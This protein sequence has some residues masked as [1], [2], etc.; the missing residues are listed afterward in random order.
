MKKYLLGLL[1]VFT[2]ISSIGVWNLNAAAPRQ[3]SSGIAKTN[4]NDGGKSFRSENKKIVFQ[5]HQRNLE[6]H[7]YKHRSEFPEYKTMQEYGQGAVDF[8]SKPPAGTKFKRRSNGDR[9]FYYEKKNMFGVT[10]GK[11]FIKTF[12]R[13]NN[14]RKYW[15]RQ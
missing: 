1:V 2:C 5:W 8:F 9:L 7:F 3:N 14:G 13:P 6:R 12:F 4:V 10:T 11:G 15:N